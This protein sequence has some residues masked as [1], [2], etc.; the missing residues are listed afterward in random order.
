[1]SYQSNPQL[2]KFVTLFLEKNAHIN[3]SSIRDVEGVWEKHIKDSLIITDLLKDYQ[4]QNTQYKVQRI[5]VLD[6]GTG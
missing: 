3:L 1:M 2:A 4:I 6:L 5:E